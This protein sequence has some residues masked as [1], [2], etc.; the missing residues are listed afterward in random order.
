MLMVEA[1]D[2]YY[3]ASGY[4]VGRVGPGIMDWQVI[5]MVSCVVFTPDFPHHATLMVMS[6][7]T[8]PIY[9]DHSMI[10][11]LR[12]CRPGTTNIADMAVVPLSVD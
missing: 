9:L 5:E 3:E 11:E 6:P 8:T 2:R 12:H 4:H 7:G 10:R 1:R